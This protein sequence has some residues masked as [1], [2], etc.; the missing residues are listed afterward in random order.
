MS[1]ADNPLDL[2]AL[3]ARAI[4]AAQKAYAPYSRLHVCASLLS[5]QGGTSRVSPCELRQCCHGLHPGPHGTFARRAMSR[6]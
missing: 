4:K 1:Q 3:R 2:I 5:T 6:R